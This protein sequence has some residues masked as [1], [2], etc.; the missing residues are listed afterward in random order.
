VVTTLFIATS[1]DGYIAG[2]DDELSWLFTDKD[3]GFEEF[4]STIDTLIMGRGTYDVIRKMG[5]WPYSGKRTLVVT[6][7]EKIEITTSDTAYFNGSL[8][9]LE[10]LLL[11]Q[12][13]KRSWLVGGS[14]LVSAYLSHN[15][16]E[17]VVASVHPVILGKGVELFPSGIPKTKLSLV[18][19]DAFD[20]G[21]VQLRY[22]IKK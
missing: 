4:Y 1:L 17:E 13:T 22:K 6:R 7:S 9:D 16:V 11:E 8:Q 20:G 14:E 12:G 19:A 15:L 21:L 3:F 5:R 18:S 2:P 10:K